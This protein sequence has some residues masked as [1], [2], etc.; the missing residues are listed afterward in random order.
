MSLG[1]V[2]V[3]IVEDDL[4]N[5]ELLA[6]GLTSLGADVIAR[7]R[8]EEALEV[9]SVWRPDVVLLDLVL[10]GMDGIATLRAIRATSGFATL[11]AIALTA[12][13]EAIVRTRTRD[14]GFVAHLTKPIPVRLVAE[15]IAAVVAA[16]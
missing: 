15:A 10:P 16:K 14:A 9:L 13:V 11:P 8:G 3:L 5:R 12:R 7:A 6:A 1:G 2:A 4:D